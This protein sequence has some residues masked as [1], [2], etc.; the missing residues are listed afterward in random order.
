MGT[1]FKNIFSWSASRNKIFNTCKRYY[2]Y[3]YYAHWGGWSRDAD[4]FTRKCYMLK[5]MT[6]VV[7]WSG[8]IVHNVAERTLKYL[9]NG[10]LWDYESVKNYA[11]AQW[12]SGWKQSKEQTWRYGDYKNNLNLF[13]HYYGKELK[14]E[15]LQ[16]MKDRVMFCVDKFYNGEV[17]KKAQEISS[18]NW[19]ALEELWDFRVNGYKVFVK[20]DFGI[21]EGPILKLYDWKT[22]PYKEED[23][24]QLYCYALY[25]VDQWQW[26]PENIEIILV[27]LFGERMDVHKIDID[28]LAL[29]RNTI[30]ENCGEMTALLDDPA[31]NIASIEKFP[32]VEDERICEQCFFKEICK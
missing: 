13:E 9:R 29:A 4:R 24:V 3:Q 11:L 8:S 25:A 26:K 16:E 7:M 12:D 2:Y 20:M 21:Q 27:Y 32:R 31:E 22:G 6:N 30:I 17:F 15:Y 28:K 1:D 23:V 10:K 14:P 19:K 5:N 18:A